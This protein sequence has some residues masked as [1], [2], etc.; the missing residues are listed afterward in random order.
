MRYL[1]S[2][3]EQV[4]FTCHEVLFGHLCGSNVINRIIQKLYVGLINFDLFR[5]ELQT[6]FNMDRA[7]AYTGLMT[8]RFRR[9]W[10]YFINV[11]GAFILQA[12]QP[13][14]SV[15]YCLAL[16]YHMCRYVR[17]EVTC[18]IYAVTIK[19]YGGKKNRSHGLAAIFFF[20]FFLKDDLLT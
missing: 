14:V 10:E 2:F 13:V 3:G 8:D 17:C 15:R 4:T 9:K 6:M 20:F 1:L 11:T 7:N 12:E 5:H 16:L 19:R 18:C